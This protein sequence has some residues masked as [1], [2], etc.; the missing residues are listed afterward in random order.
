[1]DRQALQEFAAIGFGWF[2]RSG[3]GL[4][5]IAEWCNEEALSSGDQRYWIL[6][7][8]FLALDDWWAS[9]DARGGIG[10]NEYIALNESV[11]N[12]LSLILDESDPATAAQLAGLLAL[13][14]QAV[15]D[16]RL[17]PNLYT[18]E[19]DLP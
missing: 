3:I 13:R 14:M 18:H 15:M 16:G 2:K 8:S 5:S 11:V 6:G 19:D 1:M 9:H 7:A 12:H 17:P 10:T 4:D